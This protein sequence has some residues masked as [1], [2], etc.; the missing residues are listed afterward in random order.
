MFQRLI[1]RAEQ[2]LPSSDGQAMANTCWA[3][4]RLQ[5]GQQLVEATAQQLR[6][7]EPKMFERLKLQEIAN[8]SWAFG[9]MKV[10]QRPVLNSLAAM[11]AEDFAGATTQHLSNMVWSFARLR[12]HHPALDGLAAE[13]ASR[14]NQFTAQETAN[15][16]WAFA[17]LRVQHH[18]LMAAVASRCIKAPKDFD[19]QNV[20]NILWSCG[21]LAI[22]NES[23]FTALLDP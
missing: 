17:T 16:S 9:T 5:L 8:I 19:S 10:M 21:T 2:L 4:A 12:S 20:A 22:V 1:L 14:M 13:A 11:F 23:L 18:S 15:T 7:V 6:R 3:V